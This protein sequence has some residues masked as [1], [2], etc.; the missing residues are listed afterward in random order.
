MKALTATTSLVAGLLAAS[1][2]C[3]GTRQASDRR[4]ALAVV[5]TG[6]G[7]A[8]APTAGEVAGKPAILREP[9]ASTLEGRL[10]SALATGIP[11]ERQ[12][13]L[14]AIAEEFSSG[15]WPAA[16]E[17]LEAIGIPS[18]SGDQQLLLAAWAEKDI[19]GAMAWAATHPLAVFTVMRAWLEHDPDAALAHLLAADHERDLPWNLLLARSMEQLATD[20]ARLARLTAGLPEHPRTI[21]LQQARPEFSAETPAAVGQWLDAFDPALRSA[22]LGFRLKGLTRFEDQVALARAFPD[23]LGTEQLLPLYRDWVAVDPDAA[24][25]AVDDMEP[26]PD[27]KSAFTGAVIGLFERRKIAAGLAAYRRHPEYASDPLLGEL[28][29]SFS[30]EDAALLLSLVPELSHP[31]LRLARYREL[32]SQWLR[33]D[34]GAARRWMEENPV[35]EQVR[36]ELGIDSDSPPP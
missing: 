14:L 16:L 28:L 1:A 11:A 25:A 21:A 22:M 9:A 33:E 8:P 27:R 31:G 5:P 30:V 32:L 20:P 7:A 15:D 24:V 6:G 19:A 12:R 23:D 2:L 26:G 36:R 29:L 17:A 3:V 13:A 10:R 34:A 35:P 4:R 18:S